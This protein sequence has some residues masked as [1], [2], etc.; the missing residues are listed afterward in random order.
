MRLK[1]RIA[2][3]TG[4][5]SG[6]G[7]GIAKLFAAEGA[8]VT[9]ADRNMDGAKETV[10]AIEAA[11]GKALAIEMDVTLPEDATRMVAETIDAF[12]KIDVLANVAGTGQRHAFLD[13]T[14]EEFDRV[15]KVNLYGT[16]YCAQ[17]AGRE[18]VKAGYGRIVNIASI[19]GGT[20][21]L[22]SHGL[23]HVEIRRDRID[24]ASR[25]GTWPAGRHGER[26]RTGARRYPAD[27][28]DP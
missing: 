7:Q 5:G 9:A 12:G 13:A 8:A 25:T 14:P 19:A 2:I 27:A 4:G 1:N 6:I 11:G 15:M 24:P 21:G 23:W 3:V 20:C 18:M 22:R 28:C 26:R 16:L 17:A 10:A